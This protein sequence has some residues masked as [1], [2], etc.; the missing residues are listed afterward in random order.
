[1]RSV[2]PSTSTPTSGSSMRRPGTPNGR[3]RSTRTTQHGSPSPRPVERGRSGFAHRS[4]SVADWASAGRCVWEALPPRSC[5]DSDGQHWSIGTPTCCRWRPPS[6][7]TPTT[8]PHPCT[9]GS[10]RPMGRG[11][12]GSRHRCG[13]DV[14]LWIPEETT[15]TRRLANRASRLRAVRRCRVQR[16]THRP[17][18]CRSRGGRRRR[19]RRGDRRIGC[20]RSAGSWPPALRGSPS[21]PDSMPAPGVDGCRAAGRRSHS[22]PTLAGAS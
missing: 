15:S 8:W 16:R 1:M 4:R 11:R 21:M 2:S 18:G 17:V 19:P 9:A 3:N 14:V 6:K 10:S 20:T 7:V 22:S 5:S 12:S 13:P